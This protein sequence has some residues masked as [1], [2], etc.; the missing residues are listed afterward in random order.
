MPMKI[1]MPLLN[2]A[3]LDTPPLSGS[4]KVKTNLKIIKEV[5]NS[6]I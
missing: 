5:E 3:L 4:L 2:M 6:S 1:K